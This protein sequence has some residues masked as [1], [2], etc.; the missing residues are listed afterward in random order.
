MMSSHVL[1]WWR[2]EVDMHVYMVLIPIELR[3]CRRLKSKQTLA[4]FEMRKHGSS[5][6]ST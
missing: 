3:N 4:S 5:D 2:K 1:M 6:V